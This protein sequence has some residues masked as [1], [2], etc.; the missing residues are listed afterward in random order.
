MNRDKSMLLIVEERCKSKLT[1]W[2]LLL[3]AMHL[4]KQWLCQNCVWY[5]FT[6][7]DASK[8]SLVSFN[9]RDASNGRT[10]NWKLSVVSFPPREICIFYSFYVY[11]G[12]NKSQRDAS[13]GRTFNWKL[14]VVSFPP[15]EICIFYSFYVYDGV[16][17]GQ[18]FLSFTNFNDLFLV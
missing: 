10:F 17:K 5:L 4:I 12:V 6:Q 16:N 18:I 15:R 13:N 14:S 9:Q 2:Y 11:N 1:L 7:R 3:S 8:L